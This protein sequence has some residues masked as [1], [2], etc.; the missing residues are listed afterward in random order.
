MIKNYLKVA[1]RYLLR[2]KGYTSINILGLA[3]GITCCILI[4]MFV[5]SEFSYD[6]FHSKSDRI[7]RAWVVEHYDD[8]DDIIDINTPLPL[9]GALQGSF[10]EVESTCRVF[11]LNSLVKTGGQSFNEDIRMVD[12]TFFKVFDFALLQGDRE[13]P[14]PTSNSILLTENIAKKYFGKENA[15][16]K[17]IELQL[18]NEKVLFSISGIVKAA[19]EESSIKFNALIPF[20]NSKYIFSARAM[21]A[22]FSISPETYVLLRENTDPGKLEKKLPS[23]VKQHLGEDYKEGGYIVSLQPITKIHLD[24][25]LPAGIEPISNPKYSYI[26]LTIGILILLVACIN[27]ITLSVGR[28]ATRAMEVGVRKV[29]GAERQQLVR[30]FWGEAILLTV[31]SVIIGIGL[32][33]LLA[34]PFNQIVNRQLSVKFDLAFIGYCTLIIV[35]I[36]LI[37][38]IYPA[39]ILSG[40]KPVEVLKG[41]LKL[42]N[43]TGLL[44][45]TLITGQFVTSIAMIVCTIVIGGQLDF[46]QNKDLGYQKEQVIVVPTNKPRLRGM[47]LAELYRNELLKQPQVAGASVSLMSFSETPWINIGYSDD[48]NVYRNFQF[49]AVDPYFLKTM[50]IQVTEGRDF[51]ADNPADYTSSMIVNEALVKQF[52]WKNA[53]GQKLPGRIEQQII[54]VVK[55][56]NY[57]SL[58]TKVEPLAMVVKPD[59]FFRRIND[60]S[61]T[62]PLQP[63]ISVRLKAGNLTANLNTLKQVWKDVAPDQEFEYRFLD[64]TVAAQYRQ[65]Q[66]TATI[67]KIA[68]AL[69]IFIACM[70]LFGLATLTVVR[71]TREIGIRKVLGASVGSVVQLL[72]REFL[73]LVIIAALIA[74]PLGWWAMNKWLEDFAYRIHIAWWVFPVAGI[75]ALVIALLTVSFQA[76]K[77][78]LANPVKSLR[79]E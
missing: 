34:Q 63:R 43:K 33:I 21:Q 68:S 38:G 47:E 54:G 23:M 20:S 15:I 57:Q 53:V 22:W 65:E 67:V 14:F 61:F 51:S 60:I 25:S 29:L 28:S 7:Y 52:G 35:V 59:T 45:K 75:A 56:F 3:I 27:F 31:L 5:R 10:G 72:S 69:S 48:K 71:R 50:G 6:K 62:S 16:G 19:P 66:R 1:M 2:N 78:A 55:D 64:E 37:A 11:N 41:K 49:N 12:S 44:R 30:Q 39:I 46:L 8:Q 40:F 17:N 74:F 4:M 26:L 9:A 58:H 13:N 77:A 24:T 70:G 36:G 79:T 42:G 32:T 76:I 73:V 18:S